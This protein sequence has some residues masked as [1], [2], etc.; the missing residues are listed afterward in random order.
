M[1]HEVS[2]GEEVKLP[3]DQVTQYSHEDHGN[4]PE[5]GLPRITTEGIQILIEGMHGD[6]SRWRWGI[7]NHP[8]EMPS[9]HIRNILIRADKDTPHF[10]A[11]HWTGDTFPSVKYKVLAPY[12]SFDQLDTMQSEFATDPP[13]NIVLR[14]SHDWWTRVSVCIDD[15][16]LWTERERNRFKGTSGPADYDG[17]DDEDDGM[18]ECCT[19]PKACTLD[20]WMGVDE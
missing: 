12:Y 5:D 3:I 19:Q 8:L 6:F 2:F 13:E 10:I 16:C 18:V 11:E 15:K 4:L 7:G 14:Q 20:A 1:I 9:E 17:E